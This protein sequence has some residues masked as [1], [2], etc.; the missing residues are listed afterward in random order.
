MGGE[1][2]GTSNV[3]SKYEALE[4]VPVISNAAYDMGIERVEQI[5]KKKRS[6]KDQIWLV[7]GWRAKG[8]RESKNN[9]FEFC[10]VDRCIMFH[11]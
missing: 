9:S 3:S 8:V 5:F 4:K 6:K 2:S 11:Q 1:Y 7:I 10:L